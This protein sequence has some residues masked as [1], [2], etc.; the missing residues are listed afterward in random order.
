[1][2]VTNNT[3]IYIQEIVPLG[4]RCFM[5]EPGWGLPSGPYYLVAPKPVTQP[6]S[7]Q[8]WKQDA[9]PLFF[10][11]VWPHQQV[12]FATCQATPFH[13]PAKDCINLGKITQL[14][15]L[16][17]TCNMEN[18]DKGNKISVELVS[19]FCTIRVSITKILPFFYSSRVWLFDSIFILMPFGFIYHARTSYLGKNCPSINMV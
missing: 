17:A 11:S 19:I 8:H 15:I 7:L 12:V 3:S 5:A 10:L 6:Q 9:Q 1:M 14:C 2:H 16:I 18:C 13:Q 4:N